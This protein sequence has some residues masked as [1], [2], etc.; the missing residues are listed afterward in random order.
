MKK[1][2][3][4]PEDIFIPAPSNDMTMDITHIN[5]LMEESTK[6][7]HHINDSPRIIYNI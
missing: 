6:L 3:V 2:K 4:D 1:P 5:M 7:T